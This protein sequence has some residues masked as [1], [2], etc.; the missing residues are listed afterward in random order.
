MRNKKGFT[1]VEL[2]IVIAVIAILAGVM[3]GTFASVVKKAQKSAE[4][5]E[6]A[7]ARTEQVANDVLEKLNNKDWLGWEDFETNLAKALA[8]HTSTIENSIKSSTNYTAALRGVLDEY[9]KKA[10][11]S[12]T[13]LT[14]AQVKYIIESA[15]SKNGTGVTEAQVKAIINNAVTGTSTLT[16]A[17]VQSIVDTAAANNLKA[18]DVKTIVENA[19]K[20]YTLTDEEIAAL[21]KANTLSEDDITRILEATVPVTKKV[22]A[23]DADKLST[24]AE[25]LNSGS[26]IEFTGTWSTATVKV[27]ANKTLYFRG[28]NVGTLTIDAPNATIGV[29]NNVATLDVVAAAPNSVH[30]Y[31]E[32]ETV[33]VQEGRVVVEAAASVKKVD[34]TPAASKSVK[35]EVATAATVTEIAVDNKEGASVEVTSTGKVEKITISKNTAA[36]VSIQTTAATKTEIPEQI[37][38]FVLVNEKG[39]ELDTTNTTNGEISTSGTYYLTKNVTTAITVKADVTVVLDLNGYNISVT[40]AHAITNNGTL[41]IKGTGTVDALSDAKAALYNAYGATAVLD[42][43][44]YTRSNEN[45]TENVSG[46]NSYYAIENKGTLTVNDGVTVHAKGTFSSLIQSG[47][48]TPLYHK[49]A[50]VNGGRAVL[51]INGGKFIGGKNTVKNDYYGTATINN[52]TFGGPEGSDGRGTVLNWGLLTINGGKFDKGAAGTVITVGDYDSGDEGENGET[53]DKSSG[54]NDEYQGQIVINGGIFTGDI[55]KHE[56]A[57]GEKCKVTINAG[58]FT[59]DLTS[60]DFIEVAKTST[61]D[62][63]TGVVKVK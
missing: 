12:N 3:I 46:D 49:N 8:E 62:K 27:V 35:L 34:V 24:I 16:K 10:A 6:M 42:G 51:T 32:I 30:V 21:V 25:N 58:T 37:K 45:G 7:A 53:G 4:Q 2:V 56:K 59:Y 36:P 14:E 33:K 60:V 40:D 17:Q 41:T 31:G 43:G 13:S 57:N 19:V 63:T 48:K 5:Q 26:T 44:T 20:G 39:Q 50:N 23:S 11:E 47:W 22:K 18:A 9:V 15:L 52:G 29:Y 54:N 61:Y 28:S 55:V 38:K 1:L